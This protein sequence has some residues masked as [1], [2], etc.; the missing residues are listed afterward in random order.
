VAAFEPTFRR[1]VRDQLARIAER[2]TADAYADIAQPVATRV[3]CAVLDL[4]E[5]DAPK[6]RRS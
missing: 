6:L 2:G 3:T 1:I 5:S 4:P